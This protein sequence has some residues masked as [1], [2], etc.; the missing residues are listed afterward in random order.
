[1]I[2]KA[3]ILIIAATFVTL[4]GCGTVSI[5]GYGASADEAERHWTHNGWNDR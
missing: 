1:M 2:K 3:Y 5:N 4:T